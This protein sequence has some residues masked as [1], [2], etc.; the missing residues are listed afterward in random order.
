MT[1]IGTLRE[2]ALHAALKQW[3]QQPGDMVE[4]P[5]DGYVID[6]VRDDLLIEIQTTGFAGMKKKVSK[7]LAEGHRIR[8]VHP[9]AVERT[10]VKVGED[11]TIISR[12]RSPKHGAVTDIFTQLISFPGLVVAA[13]LEVDVVLTDE[14]E[15]RT[16]SPGKAWRRNGWVIHERRLQ[17]VL[18]SA[19]LTSGAELID[20]LPSQIPETFTTADLAARLGRPRRTAQQMA[21]CLRS[22]NLIEPSGKQG[23]A[24]KYRR[25]H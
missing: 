11:G 12:R 24:I 1:H 23:N 13:D 17:K 21:Y 10:I 4:H 16:H 14:E 2:K 8:I 9:I 7:L 15:Y 6:L 25:T 5:V 19:L 22:A 18:G 3:Y 20:L